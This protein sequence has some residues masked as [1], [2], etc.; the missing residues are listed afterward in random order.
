MDEFAGDLQTNVVGNLKKIALGEYVT[1]FPVTDE[2]D[3]IRPALTL[4]VRSL[5]HLHKETIKLTDAARAG[6]LSI[7]GDEKAFRGGYRMIIA[8]FN[9]TLESITEPV[10]EAMRLARFYASGDFTARFN[11]NIPVAG[12]FVAY[13]DALNT[14][15]IELSNSGEI[16][17]DS[18]IARNERF[19]ERLHWAQQGGRGMCAA[20][21]W[22]IRE[23]RIAEWLSEEGFTGTVVNGVYLD[24]PIPYEPD[25]NYI[26][27]DDAL[28]F[29]EIVYRNI[30]NRNARRIG[31]NPPLSQANRETMGT[32]NM[33]YGWFDETGSSRHIF[34]IV[35]KPSGEDYGI[36]ILTENLCCPGKA[37]LALSIIWDS[38]KN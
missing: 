34:L 15:G 2:G 6:D 7:R 28:G 21:I 10:N 38:L 9:R 31:D 35:R 18:M 30:E 14:I 27:V 1:E 16:P 5:D 11:E 33:L 29:L 37:D 32:S 20:A 13:R 3:E 12:E 8:G 23:T 4:M 36:V 26:T 17:L 19:W 22:S 24:T 25:P